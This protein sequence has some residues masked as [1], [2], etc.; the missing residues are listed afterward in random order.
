[1]FA[2]F[3]FCMDDNPDDAAEIELPALPLDHPC[4][5]YVQELG[6]ASHGRR[7][8]KLQAA[9]G[10]SQTQAAFSMLRLSCMTQSLFGSQ[11]D[12]RPDRVPPF[13]LKNES[14]VLSMLGSACKQALQRFDTTLEDDDGLLQSAALPARLRNAVRVRQGEKRILRHI[15]DL[16]ETA[17]PVLR[18]P[19]TDLARHAE[20]G[21][22]FADYFAD[23][24]RIFHRDAE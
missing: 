7:R 23:L 4:Y 9:Y 18:N 6:E 8:F 5:S 20:K 16:V 22:P 10:S 17:L 19:A 13:N 11:R 2:Y 12:I 21:Q 1:L 24:A 14:A 3:G 15:L